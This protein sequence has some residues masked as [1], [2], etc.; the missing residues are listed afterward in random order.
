MKCAGSGECETHEAFEVDVRCEVHET[1]ACGVC[2]R[3][4]RCLM[5]TCEASR[6]GREGHT[7]SVSCFAPSIF[8]LF[9]II[10]CSNCSLS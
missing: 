6:I 9:W 8:A 4:M 7:D 5:C 1:E 3:C 10:S 2:V